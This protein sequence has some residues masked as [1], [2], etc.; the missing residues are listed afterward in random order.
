MLIPIRNVSVLRKCHKDWVICPSVDLRENLLIRWVHVLLHNKFFW[1]RNAWVRL[2]IESKLIL[3][4]RAPN[5]NC[6]VIGKDQRVVISTSSFYGKVFGESLHFSW[7]WLVNKSLALLGCWVAKLR[8][9]VLTPR[10]NCTCI[11]DNNRV[12]IRASD[13]CHCSLLQ[14]A[15]LDLNI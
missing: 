8:L 14:I 10:V 9:F 12:L 5:E 1:R 11:R 15:Q 4:V 6:P 7:L 2:T 3:F 13:S